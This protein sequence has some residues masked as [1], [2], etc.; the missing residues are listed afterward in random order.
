MTKLIDL[1]CLDPVLMLRARV[2]RLSS[3]FS[4]GLSR[5]VGANL[6]SVRR[7]LRRQRWAQQIVIAASSSPINQ[8]LR[9]MRRSITKYGVLA[10]VLCGS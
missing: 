1:E 10:V 5:V 2:V 7:V 4:I 3:L 6:I 9:P 8:E